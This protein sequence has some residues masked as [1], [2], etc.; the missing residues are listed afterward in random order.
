MVVGTGSG[1][2]SLPVSPKI[3]PTLPAGSSTSIR[4]AGVSVSSYCP[5]RT[6]QM[7]A[8]KNSS[9][10]ARLAKIKIITT[11]M[12]PPKLWPPAAMARPPD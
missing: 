4:I 11:L 5:L 6:D 10:T 12:P 2:A 3:G 8:A 9:A 1:T 7:N